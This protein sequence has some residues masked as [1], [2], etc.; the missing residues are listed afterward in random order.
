MFGLSVF[1]TVLLIG[2]VWFR[3][4]QKNLYVLMNPESD[5]EKA[6]AIESI[7]VPS[8]FGYIGK[9]VLEVKGQFLDFINNKGSVDF[10]NSAN[11]GHTNNEAGQ[12]YPL[13]LSDHK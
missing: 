8:L 13:P 6:L 12:V 7:Q 10:G 9:S 2:I 1:I 11:S 5:V 3:S 4:F